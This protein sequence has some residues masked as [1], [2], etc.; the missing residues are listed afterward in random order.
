[1]FGMEEMTEKLAVMLHAAQRP[2]VF[3][4]AGISTESGIPDFRSPGGVWSRY[5][6][7]YYD[8]FVA[9]RDARV[10]Y[11]QMKKEFY[12]DMD[13][14]RPN[15]AHIAVADLHRLGR[16]HGLITQNIDGLHQDAG[17]PPEDVVELHGTNRRVECIKCGAGITAKEAQQILE[18]GVE[19]PDCEKCGG[20]LKPAT[21]SFGQSMPEK[22]M[23]RA[24]AWAE[25]CDLFIVI[26]SSLVVQPAASMP[27]IAKQG[28]AKL[29]II[30]VDGTPM[31]TMADMV[32]NEKAGIFLPPVLDKL[33]GLLKT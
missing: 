2:V 15:P 20:P 28:G 5:K 13:R 22:E 18:S 24:A 10:R 16:L 6:P 14:A 23:R 9:S 3:T 33:R 21:I 26:G 8:E 30:N 27:V 11:W 32:V 4:G 7:V 31:D 12:L 1:M 17:V 19:A 25:E 29:V